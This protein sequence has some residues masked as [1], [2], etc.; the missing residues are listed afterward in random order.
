MHNRV[1]SISESIHVPMAK[2]LELA[3]IAVMSCL[4]H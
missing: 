1:E 3:K 4:V 2:V